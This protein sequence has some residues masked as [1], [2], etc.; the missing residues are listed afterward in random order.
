[1]NRSG[2]VG[3]LVRTLVA[4]LFAFAPLAVACS[5]ESPAST[6]QEAATTSCEL[7]HGA[8]PAGCC[9]QMGTLYDEA[10][11]CLVGAPQ[12]IGCAPKPATTVCGTLGVIGCAIDAQGTWRTAERTAGWTPPTACSDALASRVEAATACAP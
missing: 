4:C 6:A 9:P 5:S 11:G 2:G 10:K 7:V 12:L 3:S 8:C 1:M